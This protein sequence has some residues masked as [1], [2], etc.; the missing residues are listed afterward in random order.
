M[1]RILN[2]YPGRRPG[3]SHC[4]PLALNR[5]VHFIGSV[6]IGYNLK[7][8]FV[9]ENG[10]VP[11]PTGLNVKACHNAPGIGRSNDKSPEK[12]AMNHS[13]ISSRWGPPSNSMHPQSRYLRLS[14]S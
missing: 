2:V 10:F 13:T 6:P 3:L 7:H 8:G 1:G 5:M 12:G 9:S 11:D 14:N 4:V